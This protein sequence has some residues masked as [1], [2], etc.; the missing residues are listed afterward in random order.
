M[1]GAQNYFVRRL[2]ILLISILIREGAHMRPF[3]LGGALLFT[4]NP[5][6]ISL[7]RLNTI[8][9]AK[10]H[11]SFSIESEASDFLEFHDPSFSF[12]DF[13]APTKDVPT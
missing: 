5:I 2:Y 11:Y 7:R 4:M 12:L 6:S 10:N 8:Y 1:I 3:S 13:Q 9:S